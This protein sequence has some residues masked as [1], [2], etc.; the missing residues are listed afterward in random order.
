[1]YIQNEK[2]WD[3]KNKTEK[4]EWEIEKKKLIFEHGEKIGSK[5]ADGELVVGMNHD[6]V[7]IWWGRE[8]DKKIPKM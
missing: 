7:K 4:E 5:L 3:N 2:N 6:H 8:E 1:M